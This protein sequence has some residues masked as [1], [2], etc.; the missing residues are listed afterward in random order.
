MSIPHPIPY[1]GSKRKIAPDILKYFPENVLTLYEPFAGSAA[2]TISAAYHHKAK[3][4]FINDTNKALMK[5]W[6]TIINNPEQL[7]KEYTYLWHE[8][9]GQE[10]EYYVKIRDEFNLTN[11]PF[12]FLYLLNRC[13][14][15]AIRYNSNGEFNQSA[16]NRRKGARPTYVKKNIMGVH[17]L[18]KNRIQISAVD[19]KEILLKAGPEDLV[20]MDPPYQ[21]VCASR[22]T[23]YYD[24]ICHKEFAE[25]L[26]R[27]NELNI[28]Y[29][30]SYDGKTG[31]KKY[32][33]KLPEHLSLSH[34]YINAGVSTQATLLGRNEK[35][36]ESLY[37]SPALTKKIDILQGVI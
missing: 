6:D 26:A 33:Q 27:A 5:L 35:T 28:S 1:Q 22:D 8:Q 20:Y 14:K 19:Y 10:K 9:A 2:I 12:K 17:K 36:L 11:D 16:D 15:G 29:I 24:S 18:L 7:I 4:F 31:G 13:V 32:G 21:G 37:L 3:H 34:V 30:V 25:N 23:R